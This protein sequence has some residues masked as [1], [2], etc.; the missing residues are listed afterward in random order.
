M[1][2]GGDKIALTT[3][4]LSYS[5]SWR[6]AKAAVEYVNDK[7]IKDPKTGVKRTRLFAYGCSLGANILSLYLGKDPEKSKKVLD[8]A[9]VYANPW[10]I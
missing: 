9:V 6:D 5:G 10:S 7:Y 4:K 3:P 1:F 8:A 2:R